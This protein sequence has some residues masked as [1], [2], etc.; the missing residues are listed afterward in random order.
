MNSSVKTKVL[1]SAVALGAMW[2]WAGATAAATAE[3]MYQGNGF[4]WVPSDPS[5]PGAMEANSTGKL[6][7]NMATRAELARVPGIGFDRAVAIVNYRV[8][9]GRFASVDEL[10][11]VKGFSER[12]VD[13]IR[14]LV[15]LK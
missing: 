15:T 2:L 1:A 10:L 13:A 3:P 14:N 5:D 7:L 9:N 6:N 11:K 4:H 12:D 8:A